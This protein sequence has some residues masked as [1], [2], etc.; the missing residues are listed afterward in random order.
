MINYEALFKLS[1]G[2]YIVCSG[3]KEHG[4]GFISNTF[5]QVTADPAKFASCCNKGNYTAE[6]IEKT[7][8]FSVSILKQ[9]ASSD[10]IGRFGYKSGRD[11]NKLEG[12]TLKYGESGT[13]I[14][15][16]DAISYLECKVVDK[17]D[18]GTHWMF[19]GE[20]TA[21]EMIDDTLEPLTYAHYRNA[22]KGLAPKNAPTYVDKSKLTKVE[23]AK[24]KENKEHR[25][26]ICGHIHDDAVEDTAFSDLPDDWVCPVCG[27][28]KDVFTEV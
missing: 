11:L 5:F 12:M 16:D 22:R 10:I 20:L 26:I 19:I 14:V 6:I 1:Y 24:T 25:C 8:Y 18:V 7:G 17:I 13:P 27:A 28:S 2:L 21:S 4:N 9:E 23:E 15:L 3:N